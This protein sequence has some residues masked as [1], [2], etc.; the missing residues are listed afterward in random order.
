MKL[1]FVK[2]FPTALA[3]GLVLGMVGCER[4][5]ITIAPEGLP[6]FTIR[7]YPDDKFDGYI[8]LRKRDKPGA[9]I[10]ADLSGRIVWALKTDSAVSREFFPLEKS[11]LCLA[12]SRALYEIS[13]HGD[14]LMR[15]MDS[16]FDFSNELHHEIIKLTNGNFAALTKEKLLYNYSRFG[17]NAT[18]SLVTDGIVV[19]DASGHAIWKWS[20]VSVLDTIHLDT[21]DFFQLKNDWV[22]A[23]SLSEDSD[24][25]FLVS[26]RD[27]NEVWKIN[28]R[29]GA[30]LLRYS[31]QGPKGSAGRFKAQHMFYRIGNNQYI[32]F[33]N[34]P[35][36]DSIRSSSAVLFALSPSGDT[37]QNTRVIRLPDSVFT[38][39]EGSVVSVDKNK[40]LFS[41]SRTK[42]LLITDEH[43]QV[44]WHAKSDVGFYRAYFLPKS[45][46]RSKS[47]FSW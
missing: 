36:R 46:L 30:V 29:N 7:K 21:V 45:V 8:F 25:H 24:G 41:V 15:L 12:S 33:N 39:K 3:V 34:G 9:Q 6:V 23:N 26:F 31:G 27:L 37:F 35:S 43:G 14:T 13:Y 5:Q 20:F 19:F 28:S 40:Y 22:H 42:D 17:K 38:L 32:V 1:S 47:L 10:M 11:F 4:K 44:L 2:I 18:D 16:D